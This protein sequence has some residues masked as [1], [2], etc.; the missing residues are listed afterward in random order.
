MKEFSKVISSTRVESWCSYDRFWPQFSTCNI[1]KDSYILILIVSIWSWFVH[2]WIHLQPFVWRV[3]WVRNLRMRSIWVIFHFNIAPQKCHH[4]RKIG[5]TFLCFQWRACLVLF[6]VQ[7][8]STQWLL[9]SS[10]H[11]SKVK[12]RNRLQGAKTSV[13]ENVNTR[14]VWTFNHNSTS[15][16]VTK[17]INT[18]C[19]VFKVCKRFFLMMPC[20]RQFYWSWESYIATKA[21]K[22]YVRFIQPL[23]LVWLGMLCKGSFGVIQEGWVL[24]M[25]EIFWP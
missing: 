21:G 5:L 24:P 25:Q 13:A 11:E 12:E 7:Y 16:S 2:V 14:D 23:L 3:A 8:A 15:N 9:F 18:N 17:W 1:Q 19:S 20:N 6:G 10:C 4:D 22:T